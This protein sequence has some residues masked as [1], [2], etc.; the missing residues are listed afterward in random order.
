MNET[1]LVEQA[2]ANLVKKGLISDGGYRRKGQV[3]WVVTRLG[4]YLSTD[5]LHG[6]IKGTERRPATDEPAE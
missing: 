5:A 3:V 2:L 6:L 4:Q 1:E